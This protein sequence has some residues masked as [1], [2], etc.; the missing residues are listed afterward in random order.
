MLSTSYNTAS[1]HPCDQRATT[2]NNKHRRYLQ[3]ACHT[4]TS[5]TSKHDISTVTNALYQLVR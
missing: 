4:N 3:S 1:R 2:A 5:V